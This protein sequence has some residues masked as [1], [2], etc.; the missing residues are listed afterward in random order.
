MHKEI[1]KKIREIR[2]HLHKLHTKWENDPKNDGYHKSSEGYVSV[3]FHYPN[4]FEAGDYLKDPPRITVDVYSYLFGPYR[5]HSF[6]SVEEALEEV[7]TW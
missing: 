7:K 3:T 6:N 5:L 4:W 1:F 2:E